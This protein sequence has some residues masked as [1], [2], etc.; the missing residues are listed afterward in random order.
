MAA[1][2]IEIKNLSKS[3]DRKTSVLHNA[4]LSISPGEFIVLVGPS[5]CGKSTLLRMI[6]GLETPTSG[7]ISIGDRVVNDVHPSER[8]LAMVFQDYAL[9]PHMTV[10]ENLS[11]GLRMKGMKRESISQRIE[12]VAEILQIGSLLD[13]KPAK[14]SGGQRQRVA[15]GRSLVRKPSIFLFDEPLSN[16]DAQLRS[17]MRIEISDLH[18]RLQS[19]SIYVTHDQVEAMTLAHRIVVLNKGRIQQVGEPLE[20]YN[21]PANEFVASFIGSPSMN[22]ISGELIFEKGQRIFRFENINLNLTQAFT[23]IKPG[24]YTLGM[25]PEA[26]H[27]RTPETDTTGCALLDATVLLVEPLGSESLVILR[28]SRQQQIT[29]RV[30]NLVELRTLKAG[31]QIQVLVPLKALYWFDPAHEGLRLRDLEPPQNRKDGEHA[32]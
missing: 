26:V 22:L 8:D 24:F 11:F 27:V 25:R 9:Y 4:N 29:I 3:F 19:T 31:R 16:L 20:V 14:L 13:R 6:A 5:G 10:R 2:G 12:E 21:D 7:T 32:L 1:M 18:N 23:P 30:S 15:I 28:L 17:Q